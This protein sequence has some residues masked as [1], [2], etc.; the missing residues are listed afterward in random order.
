MILKAMD[1]TNWPSSSPSSK[2]KRQH[3]PTTSISTLPTSLPLREP[4]P[5]ERP[6]DPREYYRKAESSTQNTRVGDLGL[7]VGEPYWFVHQGNCEHVWTVDSIRSDFARVALLSLADAPVVFSSR[8][9]HPSDPQPTSPTSSAP[10]PITTFLS[11]AMTLS[12]CR[13][14]DVSPGEIITLD[15]GLAGESPAL[16]CRICFEHLHVDEDGNED[17]VKTVPLIFDE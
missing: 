12:K 7:R 17:G 2:R 3:S 10:Y 14:C 5:V 6:Q 9:M 1:A 8:S 16:L 15:D 11:R 4:Q 13:V